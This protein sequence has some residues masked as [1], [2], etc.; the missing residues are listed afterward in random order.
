VK[1]AAGQNPAR[2]TPNQQAVTECASAEV[3]TQMKPQERSQQTAT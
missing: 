3:T 2:L 1:H